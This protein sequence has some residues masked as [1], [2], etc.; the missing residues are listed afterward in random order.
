MIK[1]VKLTNLIKKMVILQQQKSFKQYRAQRSVH[2]VQAH[3]QTRPHSNSRPQT[4]PH[5]NSYKKLQTK[6]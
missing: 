4:R 3:T 1:R 6:S 5:S 2:N